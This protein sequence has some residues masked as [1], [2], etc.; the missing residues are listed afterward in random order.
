VQQP[1]R[2]CKVHKSPMQK[3]GASESV[4]T[5]E[6]D[7]PIPVWVYSCTKCAEQDQSLAKHYV[8]LHPLK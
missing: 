2:K 8:L 7:V 5:D 1:D 3:H 6:G 4:L